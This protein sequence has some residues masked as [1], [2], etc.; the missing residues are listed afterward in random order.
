MR[1]PLIAAA[2]GGE[3]FPQAGVGRMEEDQRLDG[4]GHGD[5][6]EAPLVLELLVPPLILAMEGEGALLEPG[7]DDQRPFETLGAM[8]R[9]DQQAFG[10]LFPL[11][12]PAQLLQPGQ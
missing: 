5:V 7:E 8:H 2:A 6:E 11:P 9:G 1:R 10:G 4:P 3:V 12:I